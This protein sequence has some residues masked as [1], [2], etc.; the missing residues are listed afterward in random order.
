MENEAIQKL[1]DIGLNQLEAEVYYLLLR[2]HPMTAYKVGKLL[3]KPTANIYK[4]VE[5]LYSKGAIII[6]EGKNKLCKAVNPK[7]FIA[8]QESQFALKAE[9]AS[10][11]LSNL[12]PQVE[13]EKTYSLDSVGLALEKAKQ[14]IAGAQVVIVIDAFPLALDYVIEPLQKAVER[15]IKVIVQSYSPVS[16]AGADILTTPNHD[17]VIS[18]WQSQQLNLISDGK[19]SLVSLFDQ[20]MSRVFHAT[21]STNVYLSCILH[22]GRVCEQSIH[23]LLAVPDSDSKLR[24]IEEILQE[25]SFF[26]N[27]EVPGVQ[28]LFERHMVV[29]ETKQK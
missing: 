1:R 28:A 11:A 10:Q 25:Q 17:E 3:K 9:Q 2:E 23:K 15:G 22:A 27:S 7:E 4:A 16:I 13:E 14:M 19:E 29:S 6:E 18:Y 5:V 20:S 26:R 24:E 21:W 12:K 8:L